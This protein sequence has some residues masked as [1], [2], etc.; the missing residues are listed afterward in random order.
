MTKTRFVSESKTTKKGAGNPA[1]DAAK[2]AE[3][4]VR[5][6]I[7]STNH[8]FDRYWSGKRCFHR[9]NW[10]YIKEILDSSKKGNCYGNEK[11]PKTG[12]W[13]NFYYN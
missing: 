3:K 1:L 7:P 6:I 8:V 4:A 5:K 2:Y 13:E 11:N 10:D 12:K 9:T